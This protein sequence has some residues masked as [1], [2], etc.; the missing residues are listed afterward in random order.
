M[1]DA[2]RYQCSA[3]HCAHSNYEIVKAADYDTGRVERDR[4]VGLLR[5]IAS[6]GHSRREMLYLANVALA[7][8]RETP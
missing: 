2:K 4:L 7:P 6:G 5:E 3:G 1:S 8:H